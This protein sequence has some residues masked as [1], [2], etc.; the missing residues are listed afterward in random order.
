MPV[1][2]VTF[3]S[4]N[5]RNITTKLSDGTSTGESCIPSPQNQQA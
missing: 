1:M 4:V 2:F 5:H 3:N